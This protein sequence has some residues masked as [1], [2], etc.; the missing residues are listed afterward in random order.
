M[1]VEKTAQFTG[2]KD[3]VYALAKSYDSNLFLSAA[4][5]G[6][7]VQWNIDQPDQGELIAKVPNSVYAIHL[8]EALGQVLVGQNFEGIHLIDIR[9]KKELKS[10]KLSDS[11]IFDIQ[12]IDNK[13]FVACGNGEVIIVDLVNF[14]KIHAIKLSD[15]SARTDRKSVV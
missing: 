8:L 2:H 12:H 9:E 1:I 10:L 7:V 6:M 4:G 14:T 5:D 15:K 11:Y 13:I 3:C